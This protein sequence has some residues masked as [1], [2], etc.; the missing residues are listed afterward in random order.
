MTPVA[1]EAELE[2]DQIGL[3]IDL[4]LNEIV[5]ATPVS[6]GLDPFSVTNSET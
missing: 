5:A 1:P 6:T 2:T 3:P 4:T